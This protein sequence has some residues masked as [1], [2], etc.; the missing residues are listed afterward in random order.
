MLKACIIK[1]TYICGFLVSEAFS[2]GDMELL[3]TA[4]PIMLV[5]F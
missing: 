5:H 4:S 2:F 3:D 1:H